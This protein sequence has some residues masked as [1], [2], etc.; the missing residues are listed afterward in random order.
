MKF[1]NSLT[2]LSFDQIWRNFREKSEMSYIFDAC[3][4]NL[5]C[6]NGFV[7]RF[8]FVGIKKFLRTIT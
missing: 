8:K 5:E 2:S 4:E 7:F 1:Q 6:D 3:I